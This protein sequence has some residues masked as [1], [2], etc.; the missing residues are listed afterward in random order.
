MKSD[1]L[2]Q[3]YT[4]TGLEFVNGA[5]I[6]A[7][8]VVF[9][10]GFVGNMHLIVADLFGAEVAGQLED[11]WGMD[12]EGE[13]KGAFKPSGRKLNFPNFWNISSAIYMKTDA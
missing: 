13:V 7:D 9:A 6:P 2:P 3:R 4:A 10:T 11:Y 12:D 5:T 8:L 1:S